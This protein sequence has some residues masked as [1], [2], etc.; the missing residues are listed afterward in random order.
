MDPL[1]HF[2][3]SDL[4]GE[5]YLDQKDVQ[6]VIDLPDSFPND[7]ST[8]DLDSASDLENQEDEEEDE[9]IDLKE[10]IQDPDSLMETTFSTTSTTIPP[11]DSFSEQESPFPIQ[12]DS[13]VGF[14]GHE[15][16][17]VF[18]VTG[19]L[20]GQICLSGGGDD[21]AWLWNSQTGNVL[22]ELTRKSSFPSLPLFPF[23]SSHFFL[24]SI[25]FLLLPR[26]FTFTSIKFPFL[27][28]CVNFPWHHQ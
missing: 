12:D 2:N 26:F 8:H 1:N 21:K 9:V 16:D 3:S 11:Y 18:A 22:F 7:S 25:L 24:P 10:I 4:E 14:F 19:S 13:L 17:P 23:T 20:N 28:L 15:S 5:D 27:C 6:E